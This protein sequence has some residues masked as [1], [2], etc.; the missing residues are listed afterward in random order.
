MVERL[1]GLIH[2]EFWT[3]RLSSMGFTCGTFSPISWPII[4]NIGPTDPWTRIVRSHAQSTRQ[5][6]ARL[7]NCRS[8]ADCITVALG[9]PPANTLTV[10]KLEPC[11]EQVQNAGVI[12]HATGQVSVRAVMNALR[13]AAAYCSLFLASGFCAETAPGNSEYLVSTWQAEQGLPQNSVTCITQT[14]DGYL[15]IGTSNGLARFDGIRFVTY[16]TAD[17]PGLRINRIRSLCED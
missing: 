13:T 15:W 4:I 12:G 6:R 7:S 8:W 5:I 11:R 1:I 9:K 16:R 17:T 14:R 2:R 3:T 10:L